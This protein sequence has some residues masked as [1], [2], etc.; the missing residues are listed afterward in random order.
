MQRLL[1]RPTLS[2]LFLAF[3]LGISAHTAYA[4]ASTPGMGP[5]TQ[6]ETGMWSALQSANYDT[7]AASM[8]P[9]FVYVGAEGISDRQASL[10]GMKTCKLNSYTLHDPQSR[11]FSADA[12]LVT[13]S[14][15][16]D[17][18]CGSDNFKG[19]VNC[20]SLWVRRGGKWMAMS[21]TE[22]VAMKH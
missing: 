13:Y 3:I 22:A 8:L 9:D 2:V 5:V 20:S 10:T 16:V 19:D 12:V 18:T 6:Q 11:M 15:T 4:Q 1:L 14:A 7:M 21:H 17:T